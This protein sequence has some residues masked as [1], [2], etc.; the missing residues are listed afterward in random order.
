[1]RSTRRCGAEFPRLLQAVE[2]T[3]AG[4]SAGL[5]ELVA[6]GLDSFVRTR[7]ATEKILGAHLALSLEIHLLFHIASSFVLSPA[8]D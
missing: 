5:A 8:K 3:I 1:M 7:S 2:E 6:R 4:A